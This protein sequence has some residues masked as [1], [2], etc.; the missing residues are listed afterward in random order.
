M[1]ACE[2]SM[3][4]FFLQIIPIFMQRMCSTFLSYDPYTDVTMPVVFW[5]LSIISANE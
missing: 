4:L 2:T 1:F 5:S 3:L